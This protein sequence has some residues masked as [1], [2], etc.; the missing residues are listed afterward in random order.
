MAATSEFPPRPR[1]LDLSQVEG[2]WISATAL[3]G[4][5]WRVRARQHEGALLVAASGH[6][7]PRPG[8][9]GETA[10]DGVF[11]SSIRSTA[12][13]AYVVTFAGDQVSTQL[14][15]YAALGVLTGHAFHRFTDGRR[16]YFTREFYVPDS[17][18]AGGAG[19]PVASDFPAALRIG[20]NTPGEL[21]GTWTVLASGTTTNVQSLDC[22]SAGAG[23]AVRARGAGRDGPVD[24]GSADARLY[25]D[26]ARPDS[27]PAFLATF[28][29]GHMRVCL[30]A[31]INRGV[32]VVC[33]F[34][35]FTDGSGRSDYFVRECF[36]R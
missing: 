13:C 2:G 9:W 30:Q 3:A 15:A 26:A 35:E 27:P 10:A 34:T 33:E 5:I 18:R 23:L 21:L 7:Q 28:D 12:G 20:G 17:G 6:G 29:H 4:G 31:R 32:L 11:A 22:T 19:D 1:A 24:W 14:Q 8:T 25:A 16:D 36:R